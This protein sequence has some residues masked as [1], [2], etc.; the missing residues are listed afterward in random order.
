MRILRYGPKGSEKPGMLDA[1]GVIRD[2]SGVVADITPAVLA[3]NAL[4]RLAALDPHALPPVPGRVR[5]G[6]P[7]NGVGKFIGI[8]MNYRDHLLDTTGQRP[9]E[10]IIFLKAISCLN[11]PD[12]DIMLP[13][14]PQKPD[15]EA[16]LGVVVGR[17]ARCVDRA[18]ALSHVAGYVVVNDV[19]DRG[20][21]NASSQWD[22]GKGCDTFGPVGP[23][24][25]TPDEVG[26]PQNLALWLE[27]NGRRMQASNTCNMIFPVAELIANVS[28]YLTLE[29]GD[30]IATGTPI[31]AG[32]SQK[33][34]VYL[35]PGDVVRLGVEKLGVQQQKVVAWRENA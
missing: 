32:S 12:D 14:E 24:L 21:Q 19:T 6:V 15:W 33:P 1:D 10:P 23:W 29:P 30:V 25:V 17:R 20:F 26:D 34:P 16:E 3:P 27:L 22:K 18:A 35:R 31:G 11:G 28:G 5:L 4:A 2:L 8:G 13:R 9:A 7:I